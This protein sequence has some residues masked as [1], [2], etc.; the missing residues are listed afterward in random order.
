MSALEDKKS[1]LVEKLKTYYDSEVHST[2]DLSMRAVTGDKG[3]LCGMA[4]MYQAASQTILTVSEM[5]QM[6][7]DE[8]KILMGA[9]LG[10]DEGASKATKDFDFLAEYHTGNLKR[11]NSIFLQ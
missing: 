7:F 1:L 5:K 9:L 2:L 10:K 11:V 8:V 6:S 4:A 3:S